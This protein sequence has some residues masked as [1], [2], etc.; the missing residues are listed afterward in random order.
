[1]VN[2]LEFNKEIAEDR[3]QIFE[4]LGLPSKQYLVLS[5]HRPSNTDSLEH[6]ENIIEVVGNAGLPV[7][8]PVHPRTKRSME[9]YSMWTGLPANIIITESLGYL[10]M[11]KLMRHATKILTDSGGIQK[12]SY[13]LSVQCITLR[14][15]TE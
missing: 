14:E 8:F 11:L 4:R 15:N 12:E 13:I 1:M 9:E 2:A 3:S 10:D 5:V 7:I 6:M